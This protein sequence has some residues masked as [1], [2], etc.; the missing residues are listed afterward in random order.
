MTQFYTLMFLFKSRLKNKIECCL[1]VKG[2]KLKR[3][4][5]VSQILGIFRENHVKDA[6]NYKN[7]LYKFNRREHTWILAYPYTFH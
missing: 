7:V 5:P 2:T 1:F 6:Y 3:N 4:I